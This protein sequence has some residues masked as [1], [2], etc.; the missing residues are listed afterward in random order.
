MER[1]VGTLNQNYE[2]VTNAFM[3]LLWEWSDQVGMNKGMDRERVKRVL[4]E[5]DS[6]ADHV[7]FS[8]T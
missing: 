7:F 5:L 1:F 2:V 3:S 6:I 8:K 4:G